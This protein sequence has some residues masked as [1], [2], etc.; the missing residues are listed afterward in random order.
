[1]TVCEDAIEVIR[2]LNLLDPDHVIIDVDELAREWKIV[3]AG[4]KLAQKRINI[5]LITSAM[6]FEEANEALVLGAS[7]III[8][9]FLPEFHLKRAYDIIHRRLRIEGRR[10]YPRFYA[11]VIFDGTF[12]VKPREGSR[13][14]SF[15]LVNVSEI[16][17]SIRT[18]DP[19]AAPELQPECVI[20]D[21]VLRV[22]NQE[23]PMSVR[24]VFRSRGLIGIRF[25]RIAE[26]QANFKRLIHKLSLKAFGISGIK[27]RW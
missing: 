25:Q 10:I 2:E 20:D 22:D 26:G 5:I 27:G 8:K 17:A 16:G 15:E 1:M 6:T 11:G 13:G 12:V 23:F 7:G 18:R 9:P 21:A 24:V 4:L 14:Y 3:A 19:E